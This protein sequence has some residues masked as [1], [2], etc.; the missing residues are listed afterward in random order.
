M[1]PHYPTGVWLNKVCGR[2]SIPHQV[3]SMIHLTPWPTLPS[4][5]VRLECP[6]SIHVILKAQGLSPDSVFLVDRYNCSLRKPSWRPETHLWYITC[7]IIDALGS[8]SP[9]SL[10][11]LCRLGPYYNY[12]CV[13]AKSLQS[14]LTLSDAMDCSLP[15]SSVHGI[16]QQ[17]VSMPSSR[18][19]SWPREWTHISY[20]SCIGRELLY[21]WHHLGSPL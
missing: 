1:H 2:L 12:V 6:A 4:P 21:H 9:M 15:G 5:H 16:L 18:E 8:V 10:S 7:Y 11:A 3:Q 14:C 19:I 13:L 20:V 17:W